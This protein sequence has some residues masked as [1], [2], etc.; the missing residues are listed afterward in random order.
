MTTPWLRGLPFLTRASRYSC[1]E[2]K[3]STHGLN[4]FDVDWSLLGESASALI[5]NAASGIKA[6]IQHFCI[7]RRTKTSASGVLAGRH[8]FTE[9]RCP[10]M[11][12]QEHLYDQL[13][14]DIFIHN[15]M[16]SQ[17]R[18]NYF[19]EQLWTLDNPLWTYCQGLFRQNQ[20]KN[21]NVYKKGKH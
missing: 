21:E 9:R 7:R 6:F 10:A 16:S 11:H 4:L 19:Q 20:K 1:Y 18:P 8:Y 2:G 3:C 15:C 12:F 17:P 5:S 13:S 14:A